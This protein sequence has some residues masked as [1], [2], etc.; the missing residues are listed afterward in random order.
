ML[1]YVIHFLSYNRIY[2]ITGVVLL[3]LVVLP[4]KKKMSP[5]T[6]KAL[7]L[8]IILWIVCFAYRISTGDDII[9][10]LKNRNNLENEN[11]PV[12]IE[13]S[14]FNKYYSNDAGRKAPKEN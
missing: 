4:T 3:F 2:L 12:Q 9:Y 5:K 7:Y 13:A 8:G 6:Q 1:Y 14:P 10:F 11:K